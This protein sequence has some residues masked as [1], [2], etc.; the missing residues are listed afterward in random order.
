MASNAIVKAFRPRNIGANGIVVSIDESNLVWFDKV[1][2]KYYNQSMIRKILKRFPKIGA[3]KVLNGDHQKA[4]IVFTPKSNPYQS[5]IDH[6]TG[7]QNEAD[8]SILMVREKIGVKFK[9]LSP[10]VSPENFK[11]VVNF[12]IGIHVYM[13]FMNCDK[14]VKEHTIEPFEVFGESIV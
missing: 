4:L 12:V 7:D 8:F 14:N 9:D 11:Q 1:L 10:N 6:F 3:I 5:Q 13:Y 2:H